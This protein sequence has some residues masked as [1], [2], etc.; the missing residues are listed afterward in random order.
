MIAM[1]DGK[2]VASVPIVATEAVE[3]SGIFKRAWQHIVQW[4]K[5]FF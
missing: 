3:K 5:G 1:V 4:V 2:S